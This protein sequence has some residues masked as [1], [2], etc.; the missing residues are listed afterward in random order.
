M[1][2]K[3]L[4]KPTEPTDWAT[5]DAAKPSAVANDAK[6]KPAKGKATE[7]KTKSER[8]VTE[9]SS[10]GDLAARCKRR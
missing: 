7:A 2:K 1:L 9:S 5:S 6:A 10:Q 8:V 4:S 3:D